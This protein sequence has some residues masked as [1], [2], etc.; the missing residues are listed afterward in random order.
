MFVH[1]MY[2]CISDV[3][4]GASLIRDSYLD[5]SQISLV[6]N[7]IYFILGSWAIPGCVVVLRDHSRRHLGWN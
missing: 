2:I 5:R 3:K 6:K 4:T 7:L 1:I